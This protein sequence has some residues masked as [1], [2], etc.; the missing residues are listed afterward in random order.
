[1]FN[2]KIKT[3]HD[4]EQI[5][6]F[7][8]VQHSKGSLVR[9][10]VD[11]DTGEILPVK[12]DSGQRI[13]FDDGTYVNGREVQDFEKKDSARISYSRTIRKIYDIARSDSW[14]WF[15][16]L[17]FNGDKIDR[18]DYVVVGKKLSDWLSNLR[19]QNPDLKYLVVPE[20]HEDGAYH[21][22][23]LFKNVSESEFVFSG[24]ISRK[25]YE[26][27]KVYNWSTYKWGFTTATKVKDTSRASSYLCKYIT[28]ELCIMTKGRKRYWASRNVKL[29]KEE[30]LFVDPAY[31]N[32]AMLA[33]MQDDAHLKSVETPFTNVR[34]IDQSIPQTLIFRIDW[35]V[36]ISVR[37]FPRVS[38]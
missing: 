28:K 26:L 30:E 24:C 27:N 5:Q 6:I 19:R 25:N 13:E 33:L 31:L 7:S 37:L 9:R 12:K 14:D 20:Q 21:F 35:C 2:I 36:V 3:F 34:Y 10:G 4:S 38:F 1:M 32:L 16:T 23:G 29:P 15:V 8:K 22:H 18:Y 11:R 17:T